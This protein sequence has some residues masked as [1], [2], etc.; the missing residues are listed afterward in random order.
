MLGL[1]RDALCELTTSNT[2]AEHDTA[3]VV[4]NIAVNVVTNTDRVLSLLRANPRLTAKAISDFLG[5]TQRQVQRI[6]SAL[7]AE[8]RLKR[9]GAAKNGYWEVLEEPLLQN[10]RK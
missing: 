9:H 1:I 10:D 3:N 5:I 6:L 2:L 4:T 8:N 7:K